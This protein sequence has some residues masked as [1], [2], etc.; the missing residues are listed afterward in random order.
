ML[1][2][3]RFLAEFRKRLLE[4]KTDKALIR[5]IFESLQ[6]FGPASMSSNLLINRYLEK[7]SSLLYRMELI[8]D[9]Q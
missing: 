7:K 5:M 6:A 2:I 3:R 9:L 4:A 8:L 1:E